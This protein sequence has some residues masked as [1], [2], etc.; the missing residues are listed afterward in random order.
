M[1]FHYQKSYEADNSILV[2]KITFPIS[3]YG[4]FS[5]TLEFTEKIPI[6]IAIKKAE[7]FLSQPIDFEYYNR[8]RSDLFFDP[9]PYD[10]LDKDEFKCRGD[11][12]TSLVFL[13]D[14]NVEDD[15]VTLELGS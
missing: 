7:H 15:E 4:E 10:K 12:L 13:E 1:A 8:V 9:V 6:R 14:F 5:T 2:K 3:R 11:L